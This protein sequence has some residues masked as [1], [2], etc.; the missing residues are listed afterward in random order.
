MKT[1]RLEERIPKAQGYLNMGSPCNAISAS[2]DGTKLIVAGKDIVKIVSIEN[3]SAPKVLI[4]LR[5]GKTQSLNYTGNDCC[6]HPSQVE[7]YKSII[8]TAATN[9][10]VVVWNITSEGARS[11]ERVWTDHN[12]AVNKLAWHPE[13]SEQLLTGSQDATIKLSDIRDANPCKI[14]FQ[15]KSDVVRD[16]QFHPFNLNQFAAAFDNGTVQ[17][18]DI[19]KHTAAVEKITAH[20]GLVLSIEWHP[21]EKNIIASGGRDRAIRVWDITNGKPLSNISTISSVS[22]IKWRPGHKWQI[23]SC[24]SIVD[25]QTHIW[26]VKRPFIPFASF[27]EHRDVPTGLL[28]RDPQ[29][30]ITCSKDNY[31]LVNNVSD[32]YQPYH[33]VRTTGI[34]WNV[35]NELA[36]IND[37]INRNQNNEMIQLSAQFPSFFSTYMSGSQ[38]PQVLG[39]TRERGILNIHSPFGKGELKMIDS[40]PFL[41]EFFAKN[42]RFRAMPFKEL[43]SHNEQV[44]LQVKQFYI[45]KIWSLIKL[46]YDAPP[47]TKQ[48]SKQGDQKKPPPELPQ[49]HQIQVSQQPEPE[50]QEPKKDEKE[51]TMIDEG[52]PTQTPSIGLENDIFAEHDDPF[53]SFLSAEAV[54]PLAPLPSLLSNNNNNNNINNNNTIQSNE[55]KLQQKP[56]GGGEPQKQQQKQKQKQKEKKGQNEEQENSVQEKE[57]QQQEIN[58]HNNGID[59]LDRILENNRRFSNNNSNVDDF[60]IYVPNITRNNSNLS[61]LSTLPPFELPDFD[62][63][64]TIVSMLEHCIERGDIQTCVFVTLV[65]KNIQPIKMN[66]RTCVSKWLASYVELLHRHKL[67]NQSNEIIKYC[68][69]ASVSHLSQRNTTILVSCS[70]GKGILPGAIVCEK[71]GTVPSECSICKLPVKGAYDHQIL[72]QS[73]SPNDCSVP[74]GLKTLH[75]SSNREFI[76]ERNDIGEQGKPSM[77]GPVLKLPLSLETFKITCNALV[78]DPEFIEFPPKL[79]EFWVALYSTSA[80]NF[81]KCHPCIPRIYLSSIL[82]VHQNLF[83]IGVKYL[84]LSNCNLDSHVLP[85]SIT[86]LKL[87]KRGSVEHLFDRPGNIQK[88]EL[89]SLWGGV[90]SF[91]S[92]KPT[93]LEYEPKYLYFNFSDDGSSFKF[94]ITSNPIIRDS[95]QPDNIK[96]FGYGYE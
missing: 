67:W 3:E 73:S 68:E 1:S 82:I 94:D 31:L 4:N 70:C 96:A 78:F 28:W 26:G 18:W 12:R 34:G 41:F 79:C 51:L 81:S 48:D 53:Q 62:I 47:P 69:E 65:L 14:T 29:T 88:V 58:N 30:L 39:P 92:S 7:N 37:K 27:R 13:K 23:A 89:K 54:T 16:V 90:I 25:L 44:A 55:E 32:A 50:N 74:I 61:N 72:G 87:V 33:H 60:D 17:L 9:G 42:Y 93:T 2:P 49:Q 71:C 86:K 35:N 6:W 84:S 46:Y 59:L 56:Q 19:R 11:V 22:R 91:T 21:E 85:D 80:I 36:T 52:S 75:I 10:A 77:L 76:I 24:S 8:A 95:D 20:Q 5:A 38:T 43:C 15:P 45:S 64:P 66:D 57:Y 83:S 63:E 40:S